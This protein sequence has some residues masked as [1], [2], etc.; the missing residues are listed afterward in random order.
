VTRGRRE[1]RARELRV[2]APLLGD[3]APPGPPAALVDR[4]LRAA[5][6]E[7]A[8][9]AAAA[10]ARVRVLPALPHGYAR[11]LALVLAVAAVPA[12]LVAFFNVQVVRIAPE[13]LGRVL[14]EALALALAAAYAIGSFG[15]LA[16]SLGS[17]PFAAHRRARMRGREKH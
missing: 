15:W 5:R 3:A 7:L 16:L 6:T 1:A 12:L 14:P 2:L 11:E 13:L 10:P 9:T 4:T 17:L 8:Q